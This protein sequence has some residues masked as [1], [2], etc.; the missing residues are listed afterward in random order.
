MG[1]IDKTKGLNYTMGLGE[2]YE[3]TCIFIIQSN[4]LFSPGN[5]ELNCILLKKYTYLFFFSFF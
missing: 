4:S 3:D 1:L 5:K 2:K